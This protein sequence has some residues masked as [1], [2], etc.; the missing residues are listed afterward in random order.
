M[1]TQ[2]NPNLLV[3]VLSTRWQTV[4]S[5]LTKP[6][7]SPPH[8]QVSVHGSSHSVAGCQLPIRLLLSIK[9]GQLPGN[10]SVRLYRHLYLRASDYDVYGLQK[11]HLFL[12]FWLVTNYLSSSFV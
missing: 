1:S 12:T 3:R 5:A 11:A 10:V 6:E 9:S 8:A 7:G 4:N 2:A